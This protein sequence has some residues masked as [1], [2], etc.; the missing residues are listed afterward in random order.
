MS[1]AMQM[2]MLCED[3]YD[4][5]S[6]TMKSFLITTDLWDVVSG[7]SVKPENANDSR[8][9]EKRDS[10]ALASIILNVKPSQL[11]HIK[12]FVTP[13]ETWNKLKEVHRPYGPIQQVQLY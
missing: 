11:I 1:I 9:W 8:I 4:P 13:L 5:W 10:K 2:D 12:N 3:N 7:E 6:M